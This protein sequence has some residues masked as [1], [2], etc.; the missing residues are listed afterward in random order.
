MK[1]VQIIS[2]I[3][4]KSILLSMVVLNLDSKAF[5]IL[6]FSLIISFL[7]EIENLTK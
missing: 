5:W 2:K 7:T 1:K 6:P 3:I 4:Y